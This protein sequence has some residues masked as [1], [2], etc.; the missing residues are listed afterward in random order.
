MAVDFAIAF[1]CAGSTEIFRLLGV[2]D[3][4]ETLVELQFPGALIALLLVLPTVSTLFT[5][6]LSRK[7]FDQ[8]GTKGELGVG[9]LALVILI[10]LWFT[11]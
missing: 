9:L 11:F 4:D 5:M 2:S 3:F 1:L 10:R 7:H 8:A 6:L